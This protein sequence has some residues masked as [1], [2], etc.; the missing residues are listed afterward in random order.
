[1]FDV[2]V[3][4]ASEIV[5]AAF[6]WSHLVFASA[7]Y[8][9]GIFISMEELINNLVAHNI[10]NRTVAIIENGTWSAISGA[11]IRKKLEACKNISFIE[12]TV[13]L[14]SSLKEAQLPE[15]LSMADAIAS[16]V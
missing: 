11:L 13:S 2:S 7:T 5:A 10:Q 12:Q 3:T 15:I 16:G 6:K 14:K 8:N 1:M 9:A 4:H